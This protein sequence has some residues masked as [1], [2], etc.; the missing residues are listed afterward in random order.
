MSNGIIAAAGQA[1]ALKVVA[2]CDLPPATIE[3]LPFHPEADVFKLMEGKE[4]DELT[5]DIQRRGLCIP[6]VIHK[7]MIIDGRNRA[8][9]CVRAGVAP[10]YTQ[11]QGTDADV[12][13]FIISMNIHRRHLTPETRRE[14][15]KKLLHLNPEM[16]NRAIAK[17][18][19]THHHAVAE[20]RKDEERRGN[21]SH[22]AT[23]T[24]TNGCIQPARKESMSRANTYRAMMLGD[25]AM[26]KIKGTT[27]DSAAEL[28]A[29]VFLNRG[30]K[31]GK[32]TKD[33]RELVED[34]HAGKDVSAIAERANSVNATSKRPVLIEAWRKR[35]LF[36]WN[37]ASKDE[38]ADLIAYLIRASNIDMHELAR[39]IEA[40]TDE[41]AAS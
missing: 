13:G 32:L 5:G 38:K 25:E 4:F 28:D 10:T 1:P 16:S 34:A 9:A 15:L 35:M 6:I 18:A 36:A 22:V 39:L 17:E 26:E 30:A 41:G 12:S 21:L 19:G 14:L 40:T 24:D 37:Q 29:L 7:G 3:L 23:H 33:A 2:G 31:L 27:L 11:F 8:R 20:V